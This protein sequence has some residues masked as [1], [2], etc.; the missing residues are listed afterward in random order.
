MPKVLKWLRKQRQNISISTTLDRIYLLDDL[1][2][3]G[4]F[5][6]RS[7][8][9]EDA[10]DLLLRQYYPD[11][12]ENRKVGDLVKSDLLDLAKEEL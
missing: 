4:E 2:E 10:I 11:L 3:R 12:D 9:I 8:A 1:V 7:K 6:N 5:K